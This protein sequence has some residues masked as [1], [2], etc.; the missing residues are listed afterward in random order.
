MT[1]SILVT[2][3][4]IPPTRPELVPRPRLI[5][6]MNEGLHRK[7]TLI[8]APAGFGKTTLVTEW[9]ANLRL[10]AKKGNQIENGIAWLSLDEGDNDLVRFL[11]YFI[12]ALNQIE[13]I[14]ATYGKGAL[15]MLQ[16]PQ[17]PPTETVLTSLINEIATI[18]DRII[19][20]LDDY[21]LIVAQPIHDALTFLLEHQPP[22]IHLI[23][24][25]R[26]D[27]H[28]PLAG[29]RAKNQMT[30]LRATDL[31]FTSSEAAE[32][33]NRVMGLDLSAEDIAA[34]ETRTEGWI[35]GL[36]LA[37][38]SMQGRDDATN[39]IKSFT[40]SHRLVLDYL[41]EEVL[42]QQ[43][44]SIQAFLL[45]TSILDRLNGALCDALTG[46]ANGFRTLEYLDHA[47]LFIVPLDD[48]RQWY[49]YHHLFADLLHRRLEQTLPDQVPILQNKAS[50]W[51]QA[52]RLPDEA[53]VHALRA[54]NFERAVVLLDGQADALWQRGEHG[55]LRAWL[56]VIPVEYVSSR[57]LLS[58]YRAYYL[59]AVGQQNEGDHYLGEAKKYFDPKNDLSNE[60]STIK[61]DILSDDEREKLLGRL[62]LIQALIYTFSGD[63]PGMIQHSNRA[64][65]YLPEGDLT[66]RSLAAFTLG[67]AY[68]YLG[69]MAASYQARVEALRACERAGDVYYTIVAALKLASTLKEQ[70][71]FQQAMELCQQ[72]LKQANIYEYSQTGPVGCLMALWGDVLTELNYLERAILQAKKGVQ[73]TE[74]SGNLT[75]LGYSYLY[76]LRVLLSQRDL[77]GAQEI[78][79]K[80]DLLNRETTIPPWL[81]DMMANWQVRIWLER[82]EPEAASQWVAKRSIDPSITLE[83][84]DYL[85]LFDYIILARILIAQNKLSEAIVLLQRLVELAKKGGRT[86]S[87][88]EILMLQAL[89][90]QAGDNTSQAM[91]TLERALNI[92]GPLGYM[93]IFVDEGPPMASL[94]YEAL[95]RGIASNYI[96][97]LLA[98][99]PVDGPEQ[100][101]PSKHQ[102]QESELI[103]PL[104]EREI[105]VLHLI[106][107]GLTNQEIASRLF[108]SLNTVKVHT[109]NIYGKLGINNRTQAVTRARALG[110]LP[111]I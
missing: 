108:L 75:I 56:E 92:A 67:D 82:G 50:E 107:E 10:D 46:Q 80:V 48:E 109:R 34:L 65:E 63:V 74:R 84:I 61:G 8:S 23:I 57:P 69:D 9:L 20:V 54:R 99:F 19:L 33:L 41:I 32:F 42:E 43:P 100:T 5:E 51:F 27:P 55:K 85:Q 1:A 58:I 110:I 25:T 38:I 30:E 21:H 71:E 3:L 16:S 105:E 40:G 12:A 97:R 68:S 53:I 89:A 91:V 4:F 59:H 88:I 95:S 70:G 87:V 64:L 18:S 47:N 106:A 45:Q 17:P 26:E 72:Q 93:R 7:L 78:I 2:K 111:S 11:T 60:A 81:T 22:Q 44:D 35:A 98:A 13:G 66:W 96:Q 79:H 31:R 14:D 37:A 36:Q 94:L 49:R 52:N 76:L 73:I 62:E 103:E 102:T 83:E 15:S 90:Y 29:L 24:A 39:L 28:L 77:T 6:Q 86:T 101:V 104:S